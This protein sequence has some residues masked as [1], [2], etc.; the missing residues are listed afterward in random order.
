MNIMLGESSR[1]PAQPP[2]FVDESLEPSLLPSSG[3]LC[4]S[5]VM[6]GLEGRAVHPTIEAMVGL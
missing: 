2:G 6:W 4:I 1:F 3:A 5:Y